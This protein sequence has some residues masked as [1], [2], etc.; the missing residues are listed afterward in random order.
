MLTAWS[1]GKAEGEL[2]EKGIQNREAEPR[3]MVITHA[4]TWEEN[5][6]DKRRNRIAEGFLPLRPMGMR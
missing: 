1:T 4:Q 6:K 3:E 2:E 5:L